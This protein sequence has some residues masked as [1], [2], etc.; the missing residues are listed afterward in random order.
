M[1]CFTCMSER[2]SSLLARMS[3][4]YSFLLV[5]VPFRCQATVLFLPFPRS[6]NHDCSPAWQKL[7]FG[8]FGA[9]AIFL[10]LSA[11]LFTL[12]NTNL[13]EGG[14]T[15][16]FLL[17][18]MSCSVAYLLCLENHNVS[19]C[20]LVSRRTNQIIIQYLMIGDFVI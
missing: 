2:Y 14:I 15:L 13:W 4:I 9:N 18:F 8:I 3:E 12:A 1:K 19:F 11:P 16:M 7:H 20:N 17:C 5:S 10:L 6:E